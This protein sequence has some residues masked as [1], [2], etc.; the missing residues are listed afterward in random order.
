MK[1]ITQLF[2]DGYNI[3]AQG[4]VEALDTGKKRQQQHQK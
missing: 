3:S 2:T 4:V 1:Q